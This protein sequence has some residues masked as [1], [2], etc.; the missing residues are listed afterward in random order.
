VWLI[1]LLVALILDRLVYTRLAITDPARLARLQGSDLY[2][3]LRAAGSL[4]PW[5]LVGGAI[6]LADLGAG[7][8]HAARALRRPVFL[9][10]SAAGSGLTAELLKPIVGRYKPEN[11]GGHL[12]FAPLRDRLTDWHDLGMASSHAAVAFG[13]AFAISLMWP[14]TAPAVILLAIGCAITRLV[15]GAHFLSDVYVGA[16]LACAATTA[17]YHLDRSR[18][19]GTPISHALHAPTP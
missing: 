9:L 6:F 11:T 10:L 8:A 16:V 17:I 14:R 12:V 18:N 2:R 5:L 4:W 7:R 19:H 13:A 1:G 3:T 15:A